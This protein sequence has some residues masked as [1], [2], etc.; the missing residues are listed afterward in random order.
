MIINFGKRK[1]FFLYCLAFEVFQCSWTHK[2]TYFSERLRHKAWKLW[3]FDYFRTSDVFRQNTRAWKVTDKLC[4]GQIGVLLSQGWKLLALLQRQ[5]WIE[6]KKT[7]KSKT[8]TKNKIPQ[9]LFAWE[10]SDIYKSRQ[11]YDKLSALIS[12]IFELQIC[13]WLVASMLNPF[14]LPLAHMDYLEASPEM[15]PLSR[16]Q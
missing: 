8:K 11:Y 13:G 10:I 6:G 7:P 16:E 14:F 1:Y 15:F 5:M 9:K 2:Q 4:R 3:R 12:Q